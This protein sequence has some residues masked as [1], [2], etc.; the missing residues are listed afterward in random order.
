MNDK[1]VKRLTISLL[2]FV[3]LTLI[4]FISN[5]A[6]NGYWIWGEKL[7]F[8]VT[9]QFGDF[10]GGFLGTLINGASFYFLYLTLNEQRKSSDSQSFETKFYE[11]IHLHR[12]NVTEL[13]YTKWGREQMETA[14]SRK[15]FKTIFEEFIEC[16]KEILRF[17]K[18]FSNIDILLPEYKRKLQRIKKENNFTEELELLAIIDI[19]FSILYYG[20]SKES[21][22]VLRH[23]FKFRYS[24]NYY[25]KLIIYF[26]MKP[27]K[28]NITGYSVWESFISLLPSSMNDIFEQVYINHRN[29]EFDRLEPPIS[30]LLYN[31]NLVNYY[32]GHQHRLGHYFR[33]LFQ[34]YKFLSIQVRMTEEKKYYYAKK[35]RAQLSTH[36]Q[37]LLFFNSLSSIGMNW[38]YTASIDSYLEKKPFNIDDFR[39]ISKYHLIKNLPGSQYLDIRYENF[40]PKVNFEYKEDALIG[41][42]KKK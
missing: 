1:I 37:F 25:N 39:L 19:T 11:L 24:P 23:K 40:Y 12:E 42:N 33:H 8:A 34:S 18:M 35:L 29:K 26:Q 4:Y 7:D 9:G 16:Y 27:K 14:S 20:T 31:T 32:N 5:T 6:I 38:E 10:V 3:G 28:E 30:S 21:E 36:E 2:I 15:V 13:S 41:K 22:I 17:N